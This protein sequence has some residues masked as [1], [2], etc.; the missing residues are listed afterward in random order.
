LVSKYVYMENVF[1]S[2]FLRHLEKYHIL[3]FLCIDFSS[4][5]LYIKVIPWLLKVF[6]KEYVWVTFCLGYPVFALFLPFI[7]GC[8]DLRTSTQLTFFFIMAEKSQYQSNL[9][10]NMNQTSRK[11]T[12]IYMDK[13]FFYWPWDPIQQFYQ[14]LPVLYTFYFELTEWCCQRHQWNWFLWCNL[15]VSV[16]SSTLWHYRWNNNVSFEGLSD[17]LLC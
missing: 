15:S 13:H 5:T 16:T 14:N 7:F 6:I 2:H 9:R 12:N 4:Q 11:I 3:T 10:S 1:F 17:S 8:F